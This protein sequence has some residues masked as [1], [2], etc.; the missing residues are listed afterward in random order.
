MKRR[1]LVVLN[2]SS[3]DFE[4]QARWPRLE[5]I[6]SSLAELDVVFTDRDDAVTRR[7][8]AER[9][10][11]EPHDRVVAIGGDGTI[12]LV[13]NTMLSAGPARLPDGASAAPWLP[14]LELAVIPFGTANDVAKSLRLPLADL[15]QLARIAVGDRTGMLDVGR[16]RAV[17]D[18]HAE[19]RFFVDAVTVGMDADVLAARGRYRGL[20][21]YLAYVAALAERSVEQQS[22]DARLWIDDEIVDAR[23]FNVVIN[24]V[25]V[26]AGE[27]ELPDSALDDGLLDVYLFNRR[28]YV[29]KLMT[30]AVRQVDVLDL[31]VGDLLDDI[32]DNQRSHHGRR[33]RLRLAVPR[34]VQVDGELFGEANEL[35]CDLVAKL[36]V[37]VPAEVAR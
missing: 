22:L 37:A 18:A 5:S 25:P 14:A 24:N 7:T 26:Y 21:G 16:V 9:L 28:E 2:P 3:R 8:I 15:D 6:L 20:K 27:L 30:F 11:A 10:A 35:E 4:A 1:V 19:S 13:L 17:L 32:T 33:V 23:L 34:R 29:S 31:G 36:R 12:H